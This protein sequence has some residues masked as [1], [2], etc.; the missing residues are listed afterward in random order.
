VFRAVGAMLG[1]RGFVDLVNTNSVAFF[2]LLYLTRSISSWMSESEAWLMLIGFCLI[3][4][5]Q[6]LKKKYQ[7]INF[8]FKISKN[9]Y[10]FFIHKDKGRSR[11]FKLFVLT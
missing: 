11:A 5:Y 1:M 3:D 8:I 7:I 6:H 10:L 4:I 2:D 9:S